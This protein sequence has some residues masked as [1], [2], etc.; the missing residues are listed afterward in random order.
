[1]SSSSIYL[2]SFEE[3]CQEYYL[4]I[5]LNTLNSRIENYI[6]SKDE[7]VPLFKNKFIDFFSRGSWYLPLV[8]YIPLIL[9]LTVY[10]LFNF[11][12]SVLEYIWCLGGGVLFWTLIEY[13]FHRWFFHLKL[14]GRIGQRLFFI[15]HGVHHDYPNDSKRLVMPLIISFPLGGVFG[16][17]FYMAFG[18]EVSYLVFSGFLLGYLCYDMMHFAIHNSSYQGSVFLFLKKHHLYH[19]YKS[20]RKNYGVTNSWWDFLF[21]TKG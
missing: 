13:V 21:G 16:F 20:P 3:C 14:P 8:A 19:H 7:S 9:F 5:S 17:F 2:S 4:L 12:Y 10:A 1:M 6:S 18:A 11:D 15:I